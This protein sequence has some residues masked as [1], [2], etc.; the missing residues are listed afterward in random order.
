MRRSRKTESVH[1]D[2]MSRKLIDTLTKS[3]K[4]TVTHIHIYT[5]IQLQTNTDSHSHKQHTS[6]CSTQCFRSQRPY[7]SVEHFC[8]SPKS[9]GRKSE[10][11]TF[12][13]IYFYSVDSYVIET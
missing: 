3:Y 10:S 2:S 12:L 5:V 13:S 11:L 1:M 6:E 7:A 8:L 9:W 4:H